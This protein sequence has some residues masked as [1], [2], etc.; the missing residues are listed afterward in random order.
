MRKRKKRE[1]ARVNIFIAIAHCCAPK[2]AAVVWTSVTTRKTWERRAKPFEVMVRRVLV[3]QDS[4]TAP[5]CE[6]GWDVAG[7]TLSS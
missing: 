3:N 6:G 4:L 7:K 1:R 2:F 5:R